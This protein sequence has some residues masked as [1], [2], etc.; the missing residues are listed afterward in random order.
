MT[1]AKGKA[2]D[3]AAKPAKEIKV[4]GAVKIN[5]GEHAGKLGTLKHIRATTLEA[6]VELSDSG[7]VVNVPLASLAAA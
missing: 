1:K 4:G 5:E 2:A 7:K 3:T 6:H